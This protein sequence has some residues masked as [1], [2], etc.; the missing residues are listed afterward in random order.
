MK[1]GGLSQYVEVITSV[2]KHLGIS[3]DKSDW[4]STAEG[5]GSEEDFSRIKARFGLPLA[6]YDKDG[7]RLDMA[8]EQDGFP[9]RVTAQDEQGPP[10]DFF[11]FDGR[12]HF[13]TVTPQEALEAARNAQTL[14]IRIDRELI[15]E[16]VG[17]FQTPVK[18]TAG[19]F[20]LISLLLTGHELR[21]IATLTGTAYETKR[22]QL[23]TVLAKLQVSN[24]RGIVKTVSLVLLKHL[25]ARMML[26]EG[27][28]REDALA[29]AEFGDQ[30]LR[31]RY[32][33]ASGRKLPA[34]EIGAR[35]G[36][37]ILY[38]HTWTSVLPFTVDEV[39]LLKERGLRWHVVPRHFWPS[40]VREPD[41]LMEQLAT[42]ITEYVQTYIGGPVTCVANNSGTP[43]AVMLARQAPEVID[44]LVLSGCPFPP[45]RAL[46]VEK[47]GSWQHAF[48]RATRKNPAISRQVLKLFSRFGST[49]KLLSTAYARVYD[50]RPSDLAALRKLIGEGMMAEWINLFL[51][52]APEKF[53]DELAVSRVHWDQLIRS[54][55][56]P[57]DFFHG[58]D[59]HMTPIEEVEAM[60][61]EHDHVSV[62][63]IPDG[64]HMVA[65]SHFKDLVD[66]LA[67]RRL[68]AGLAC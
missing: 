2:P 36:R 4:I 39:A 21:D 64:G 19:E 68:P 27:A 56:C 43:W 23:K 53:A 5:G 65:V 40:A 16:T 12:L 42:D 7:V 37:S 14:V 50:D 28:G 62:T 58:T 52:A 35:G 38:F 8:D 3:I 48:L 24:Q 45:S 17:G 47:S 29:R 63:A 13:A 49:K 54:L 33:P 20:R 10:A 41:I 6:L 26:D 18:I 44:R 22:K 60:E 67:G 51:S 31:L 9:A 15:E 55:D 1:N 46:Q 61:E 57:V 59:D 30:I 32:T 11:E 34:W 66:F 25:S